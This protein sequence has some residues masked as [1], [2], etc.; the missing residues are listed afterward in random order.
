MTMLMLGREERLEN[1]QWTFLANEPAG[2]RE[3]KGGWAIAQM[4]CIHE[5][6][7]NK[8]KA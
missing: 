5:H 1:V 6:Q 4:L 8:N 3:R 7:K 2:G